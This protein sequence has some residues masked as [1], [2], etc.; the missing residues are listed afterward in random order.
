MSQPPSQPSNANL[1]A[2]VLAAIERARVRNRALMPGFAKFVDEYRAVF[3]EVKVIWASEN[4]RVVG[5]PP[6]DVKENPCT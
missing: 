5:N 4:G 6:A 3:G 2:E 1:E